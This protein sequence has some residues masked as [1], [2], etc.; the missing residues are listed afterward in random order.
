MSL[1]FFC[2]CIQVVDTVD[3]VDTVDALDTVGRV[4]DGVLGRIVRE[5]VYTVFFTVLLYL[6]VEYR[7]LVVVCSTS[8][9]LLLL[10]CGL[11]CCGYVVLRSA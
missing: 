8:C 10:W 5:A 7:V 2:V 1:L 9:C 4:E 3:T 6:V 11:G